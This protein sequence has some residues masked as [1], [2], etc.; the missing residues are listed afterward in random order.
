MKN[1]VEN[2]FLYL[3]DRMS[4]Q[5][6]KIFEDDLKKSD[7]LNYEFEEYK[8]LA[9]SI[10]ETKNIE[11]NK[12]YSES[13]VPNFRSRLERTDERKSYT[14]LKYIFAS[15]VIIITG[16]IFVSQFDGENKQ[17][18]KQALTNLSDD[19]INLIANDFYASDDLTKNI[20][21]ISSQKLDSIYTENLKTSLTESIGDINSNVI[22]SKNN[23]TDID[24]YLS[25][26]DI[27]LIYSQ[28]IQ[29][30]IL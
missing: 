12:D 23:V 4:S 2:F 18:L 20:T 7:E 17:E 24:Q 30:K 9:H 22:L 25:D 8:N 26:N 16:Y 11:V 29:K 10:N 14:N 13:I 6:K 5:E 19:E 28:L 3:N 15:L 1:N 21:D 27:E